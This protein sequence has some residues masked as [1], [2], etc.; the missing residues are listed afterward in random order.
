MFYDRVDAGQKLARTLKRFEGSDVVVYALPRGG[1]VVGAELA[2]ELKAPLELITARKIGHPSWEEYAIGAV[3]EKGEPVW[4][5]TER[6][7]L[8]SAQQ[9][10][11]V[12]RKRAKARRLRLNYIGDRPMISPKGK[13]AILVDD[14]IATGLTMTAAAKQLR[15]GRAK[16]I[17]IAVPVAPQDAASELEEY[18]DKII[19]LNHVPSQEFGAVG[20]FYQNFEQTEDSEVQEIM[21][22][23]EGS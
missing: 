11:L 3:T 23:F 14:G 19:A 8:S 13:T 17:I 20:A 16:E 6:M 22:E 21:A 9:K 12:D 18:A 1:A 4:N 7:G 2:R 10:L 15:A 5:E